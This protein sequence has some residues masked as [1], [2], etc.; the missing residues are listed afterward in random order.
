MNLKEQYDQDG[1]V[2]ARNVVDAGQVNVARQHALELLT[3]YPDD[4]PAQ[5]HR[6]PLWFED[7][8]YHQFVDQSAL[9]DLAEAILGPDLAL[10]A[11]GYILKPSAAGIAVLW[12][13]DGSYWPLNPMNVCTL[14]VALT[15]STCQNGCMRVIPGTQNMRLQPLHTRTDI[16]NLLDSEMDICQIDETQAVD[17][18]MQPGDVS[19]HH[20]NIVHGSNANVSDQWRINLVIRVISAHTKVTDPDWKG[21]FHLRGARREDLNTYLPTPGAPNGTSF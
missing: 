18:E 9:L 3:R 4:A 1:Y 21:V 6:R 2:I 5:I 12:H 17:M 7:A 11:T 8:F 20:P 16:P 10:F 15:P 19:I 13:Q 14:W